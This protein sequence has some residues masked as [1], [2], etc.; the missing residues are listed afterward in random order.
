MFLR[1][2]LGVVVCGLLAGGVIVLWVPLATL[3]TNR[4]ASIDINHCVRE[5]KYSIIHTQRIP[6]D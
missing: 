3:G 6:H 2:M 5:S 1:V 4:S